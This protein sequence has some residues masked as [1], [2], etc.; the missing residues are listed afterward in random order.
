M[1]LL[2][3]LALE[4]PVVR[5]VAAIGQVG[6]GASEGLLVAL[7]RGLGMGVCQGAPGLRGRHLVALEAGLL[8]NGAAAKLL[9]LLPE[10]VA[11]D[12]ALS[13]GANDLGAGVVALVLGH[14]VFLG[15]E[16]PLPA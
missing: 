3:V 12:G 1:A 11:V 8:V 5:Q 13:D 6:P 15:V 16:S 7:D 4:R 9:L 2:P 10:L 14:G